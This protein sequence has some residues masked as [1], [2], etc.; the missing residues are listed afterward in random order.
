[1][2]LKKLERQFLEDCHPYS[3]A[4]TTDRNTP[5]QTSWINPSRLGELAISLNT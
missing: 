3:M 4:Q 5:P 2:G 1:M